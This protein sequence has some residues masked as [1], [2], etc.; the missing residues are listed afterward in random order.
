MAKNDFTSVDEYIASQPEV[1]Q[2]VLERVRRTICKAVPGAEETITIESDL[3][4]ERSRRALSPAGSSTT[5]S[6][7]PPITS[8]AFK[9]AEL[10]KDEVSKGTIWASLGSSSRSQ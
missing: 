5:R 4:I 6:T 9:D 8:R 3:Q 10:A 7:R 1:V 2:D